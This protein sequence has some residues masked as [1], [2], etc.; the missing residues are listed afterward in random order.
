M[1][2]Q[3]SCQHYV[4]SLHTCSYVHLE[5]SL[6]MCVYVFK[7]FIICKYDA[8]TLQRS[9]GVSYMPPARELSVCVIRA[10]LQSGCYAETVSVC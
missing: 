8:H 4:S 3:T 7:N 1:L 10:F 2:L 5:R 9:N 6:Y